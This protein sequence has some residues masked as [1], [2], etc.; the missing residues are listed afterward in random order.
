MEQGQYKIKGIVINSIDYK[1]KDKL[2]TI[3]SLELGKVVATLR[4]VKNKNA[5]LKFAGQLFCF[6]DFILVKRGKYFVI[7]SAEQIESFYDI[8]TNY[9]NFLI[10]QAVV[11]IVNQV[12]Q[13]KM[14]NESLFIDILK[15]LKQLSYDENADNKT[16][17]KFLLT[18]LDLSG[19]KLNFDKCTVCNMPLKSP[20]YFN[21]DDGFI[22]C[23]SCHGVNFTELNNKVFTSL[24]LINNSFIDKLSSIKIDETTQK[25]ILDILNRNYQLRFSRKNKIISEYI[26]A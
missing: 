19:Y 16:L 7:T 22:T 2:V 1:D 4:G 6:A 17:I 12:M 14:I 21:Y 10:G 13:E 20:T 18:I 8:T 15:T 9:N 26:L 23:K 25:D 3:Y 11:E 5:K 24:K